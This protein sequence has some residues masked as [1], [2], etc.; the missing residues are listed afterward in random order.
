MSSNRGKLIFFLLVIMVGI[1]AYPVSPAANAASSTD[2]LMGK[3][4]CRGPIRST[5]VSAR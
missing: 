5:P 4:N 2:R 1:H 3:F